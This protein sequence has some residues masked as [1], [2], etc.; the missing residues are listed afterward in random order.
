MILGMKKPINS[1]I[2]RAA[3]YARKCHVHQRRRGGMP[4][5]I[6]P[7]AVA[8]TLSAFTND[9]EV[10]AAGWLHDVMEDCGKD[11]EDLAERF[12]TR[13][14]NY[15]AGASRDF[16][17]PK[18]E[19]LRLHRRELAKALPE[20]KLIVAADIEH[21]ASSVADPLFMK[22]WYKKTAATILHLLRGNL[23]A[24][25]NAIH[26]LVDRTREHMRA[27]AKTL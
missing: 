6:H 23:G 13:V 3:R 27:F 26:T 18:A 16:R 4:Y 25:N 2:A 19:S 22:A 10:I 5:I 7:Q 8:K 15:V 9:S 21:N 11:Y 24:Y 14:A 20:V 12:G 17:K 1:L